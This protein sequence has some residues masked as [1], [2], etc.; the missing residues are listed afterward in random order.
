MQAP[1]STKWTPHSCPMEFSFVLPS[2]PFEPQSTQLL[3]TELG[4]AAGT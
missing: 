2:V 3:E 4:A 1:T